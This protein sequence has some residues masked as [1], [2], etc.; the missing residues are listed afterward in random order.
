MS[1]HDTLKLKSKVDFSM[2]YLAIIF[3]NINF[4]QD[5]KAALKRLLGEGAM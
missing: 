1:L 2:P 5:D 4:L 3:L